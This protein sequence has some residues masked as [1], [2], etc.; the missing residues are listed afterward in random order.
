MFVVVIHFN[1]LG[2]E[3]R[4]SFDPM[5]FLFTVRWAYKRRSL[6]ATVYGTRTSFHFFCSCGIRC[7]L[8]ASS[9]CVYFLRYR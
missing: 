1:T 3:G 8:L 6:L 5:Y 7:Q 2:E 4:G 9:S